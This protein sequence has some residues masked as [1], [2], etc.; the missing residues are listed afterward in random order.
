MVN[1]V[2]FFFFAKVHTLFAQSLL[3]YAITAIICTYLSLKPQFQ[4]H[5][6]TIIDFKKLYEN[7][8]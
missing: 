8:N 6:V 3:T 4:F 5:P 1:G 7:C 2:F